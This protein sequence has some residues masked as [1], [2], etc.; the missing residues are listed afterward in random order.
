[1][2]NIS[3][4]NLPKKQNVSIYQCKRIGHPLRSEWILVSKDRSTP[5]NIT[6]SYLDILK[7]AYQKGYW[8][9]NRGDPTVIGWFITLLYFVVF[10]VSIYFSIK[11]TRYLS[12]YRYIWFMYGIT[13]LIFLLG[14]NKQLD[15]QMLLTDFA[16]EFVKVKGMYVNRKPFQIQI[17]SIFASIGIGILTFILYT[18]RF[19][20]KR[21]WLALVGISI[22]FS[23][24]IIRLISL[25]NIESFVSKSFLG[26]RI[27][28]ALEIS[29]I[30]IIL[31]SVISNYFSC[32]NTTI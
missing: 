15:F 7:I 9:Q 18:L 31:F 28:D 11:A 14:I 30:S 22:L 5:K 12:N 21:M 2:V 26:V 17:I 32:K 29:G 24:T 4:Y 6:L 20:P 10:I 23:F 19:A 8:I 27:V 13:A 1:M 3:R 16:R 25:H